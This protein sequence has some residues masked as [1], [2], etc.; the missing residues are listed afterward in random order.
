MV[1]ISSYR[2]V[3]GYKVNTDKPIASLSTNNKVKF[4]NKNAIPF[5]LSTPKCNT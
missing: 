2:M 5:T 1:L 4:E 3:A